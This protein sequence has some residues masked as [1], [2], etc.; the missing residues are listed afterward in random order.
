MHV[1]RL[2]QEPGPLS[3]V[4]GWN[5]ADVHLFLLC[6]RCKCRI[7]GVITIIVIVIDVIIVSSLWSSVFRIVQIVLVSGG[8]C[9][10]ACV[11][12]RGCV[13]VCVR[14]HSFPIHQVSLPVYLKGWRAMARGCSM[15]VCSKAVLLQDFLAVAVSCSCK[16]PW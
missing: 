4:I 9:W 13:C 3:F 16:T 1:G 10:C 11:R 14:R 2:P 15:C 12:V 6:H 5:W 8:G 7:M